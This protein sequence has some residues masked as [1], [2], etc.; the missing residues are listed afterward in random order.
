MISRYHDQFWKE[1]RCPVG[2]HIVDFADEPQF[3]KVSIYLRGRE[4]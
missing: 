2:K 1:Y 4:W 3:S